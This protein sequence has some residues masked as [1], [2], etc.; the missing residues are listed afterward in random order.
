[1]KSYIKDGK[2]AISSPMH[3]AVCISLLRAPVDATTTYLVT[4]NN[5]D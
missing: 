5:V 3:A 2:C 1:M 4:N